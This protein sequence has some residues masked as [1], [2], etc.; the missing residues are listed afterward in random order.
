MTNRAAPALGLV[1]TAVLLAACTSTEDA[2]IAR[3]F[4][5]AYAAGYDH[6]CSSGQLAGGGLFGQDRKDDQRYANE[7][8]YTEGWD[9]GFAKCRR[10]QQVMT[11]DARARNPSRDK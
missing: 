8:D 6:G 11:A 4:S 2:L 10:D 5:P 7:A 3:G 1:T 9:K